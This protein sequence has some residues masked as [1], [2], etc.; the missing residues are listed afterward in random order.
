[1]H[2]DFFRQGRKAQSLYCAASKPSFHRIRRPLPSGEVL[3]LVLLQRNKAIASRRTQSLSARA[4]LAQRVK[5]CSRTMPP[6]HGLLLLRRIH[7]QFLFPGRRQ[8]PRPAGRRHRGCPVR[9]VWHQL[10][11]GCFLRQVSAIEG[12]AIAAAVASGAQ[13]LISTGPSKYSMS[14]IC[15]RYGMARWN[16]CRIVPGRAPS[17]SAVDLQGVV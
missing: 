17:L 9:E 13:S 14:L 7:I 6:L 8:G 11:T 3:G 2:R 10:L 15:Q 12:L 16:H 1:M 4:D 5:Q